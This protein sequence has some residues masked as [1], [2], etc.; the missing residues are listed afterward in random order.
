MVQTEGC[1]VCSS[2]DATPWAQENGFTAV[3]CDE[4][5][6]VYISPWPDLSDRDRSLQHGAHA[7]DE[8]IDTNAKP[9]G[10]GEVRRYQRV[11]DDMYGASLS[12]EQVNWLD[13]G[14]GY[15]EFLTALRRSVKPGSTLLGSEP[16]TRKASYA[17]EQGLDV[18]YRNM[19]DLDRG[20]THISLLNVFSHL[21]EPIQFISEARDLLREGGEL[22]IQTGNGGDVERKDVPGALWLPDH[23]TFAGQ[24]TLEVLFEKLDMDVVKAVNYREPRAT[25]VNIA[26][27]LV[28]RVVRQ[29]HNGVNWMGPFRTVWLRAKKR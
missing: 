4:C 7:G 22:V 15:G 16:N 8:I 19:G 12:H 26:K 29:N 17:R 24:S 5:N 14:C 6:L 25:P 27:D 20:F 21:P 18:C 28:K 2:K 11:L 3:K 13:I 23:L 1:R 10:S 9:G